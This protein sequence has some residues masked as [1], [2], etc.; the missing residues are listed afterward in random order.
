MSSEEK[1][2]YTTV[3]EY[4]AAYEGEVRL[5]MEKLR[6]MIL[7][8]SP[9][10]TEKISW[11]MPTFVLKGNLIHFSGAKKH[12]GLYPAPGPIEAFADRLTEY[13]CSKGAIQFPYNKPLPYE[14]IQEIITFRIQE[15][16]N[17]N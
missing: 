7:S 12:L 13:K 10:I 16:L 11:G 9:D 3:A 15:N 14:L 1:I 2:Q 4:I 6:E 17:E 8:S 5:R